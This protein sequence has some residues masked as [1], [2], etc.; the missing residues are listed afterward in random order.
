MKFQRNLRNNDHL[1]LNDQN[2]KKD[3]YDSNN[4]KEEEYDK[5]NIPFKNSNRTIDLLIL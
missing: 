3:K 2:F 1:S 4:N 5:E